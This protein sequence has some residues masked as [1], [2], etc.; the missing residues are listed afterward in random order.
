MRPEAAHPTIHTKGLVKRLGADE[1][2]KGALNRYGI[3]HD[4]QRSFCISLIVHVYEFNIY[5]I[6]ALKSVM[7]Q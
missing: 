6:F 4:K 3:T 2:G 5:V 7:V 1:S